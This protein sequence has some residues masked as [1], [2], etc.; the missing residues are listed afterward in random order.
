MT[1][2]YRKQSELD[3]STVPI[4]LIRISWVQL[5]LAVLVVLV[6]CIFSWRRNR[7]LSPFL[8]HFCLS[9]QD[10]RVLLSLWICSNFEAYKLLWSWRK[11]RLRFKVLFGYLAFQACSFLHSEQRTYRAHQRCCIFVGN[12]WSILQAR[13]A[14]CGDNFDCSTLPELALQT[15]YCLCV[16]LCICFFVNEILTLALPI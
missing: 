9:T 5:Q 7:L 4:P 11:C 2:L 8:E 12:D 3:H 1:F 14:W 6:L 15:Y 13:S 10:V 16:C